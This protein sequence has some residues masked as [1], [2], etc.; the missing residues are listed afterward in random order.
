MFVPVAAILGCAACR[1]SRQPTVNFNVYEGRHLAE[2]SMP[3]QCDQL[4]PNQNH[5]G[6]LKFTN[7][8][9]SLPKVYFEEK[10]S[11]IV[12]PCGC[13]CLVQGLGAGQAG[14]LGDGPQSLPTIISFL[15]L[16]LSS[17][18]ISLPVEG[19]VEGVREGVLEAA[20]EVQLGLG[21]PELCHGVKVHRILLVLDVERAAVLKGV[22]PHLAPGE[23]LNHLPLQHHL[24]VPVLLVVRVAQARDEQLNHPA[25][26]VGLLLE[27]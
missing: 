4:H 21:F 1:C 14:L 13:R 10:K 15:A 8:F 17:S 23:H 2:P 22:L 11:Q 26:H 24:Q 9:Q 6:Q 27:G 12:T 19:A 7:S 25:Q 3:P 18:W 5:M 20:I 16:V